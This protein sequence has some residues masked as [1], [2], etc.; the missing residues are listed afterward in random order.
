MS[1][2]LALHFNCCTSKYLNPTVNM[3]YATKEELADCGIY[4]DLEPCDLPPHI[5]DLKAVLLDFNWTCFKDLDELDHDLDSAWF[6][7]HYRAPRETEI[8]KDAEESAEEARDLH[9]FRRGEPEW[10]SYYWQYFTKRFIKTSAFQADDDTR[11]GE[12]GPPL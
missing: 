12:L 6:K 4:F 2:S 11:Y 10:Q 1:I 9:T 3:V 7:K 5:E 8:W